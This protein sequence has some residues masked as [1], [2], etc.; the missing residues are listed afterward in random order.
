MRQKRR[1]SIPYLDLLLTL[2][3]HITYFLKL[4][5]SP[6]HPSVHPSIHLISSHPT[7]SPTHHP[8]IHIIISFLLASLQLPS[9]SSTY[10]HRLLP[11]TSYLLPTTYHLPLIIDSTSSS[12]SSPP[13]PVP[14]IS[15]SSPVLGRLN[16]IVAL[17]NCINCFLSIL[18]HTCL[19]LLRSF[20][21]SS[22]FKAIVNPID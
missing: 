2:L 6:I 5:F 22:F 13:P 15:L 17:L 21:N 16:R 8:L 20:R 9:P 1:P 10:H 19:I 18:T 3:D 12:S 11:P 7:H 14:Q 4:P